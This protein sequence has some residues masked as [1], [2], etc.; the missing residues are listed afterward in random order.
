MPRRGAGKKAFFFIFLIILLLFLMKTTVLKKA[1]MPSLEGVFRDV[2]APV[3]NV[4]VHATRWME[5]VLAAPIALWQ[6]HRQNE[7]LVRE[8]AELRERL[9][10]LEECRL[11]N[12]RLKKL[13]DLQTR[14]PDNLKV[15][16]A[17]VID[18]DPGNWFKTITLNK[19]SRQGVRVNMT[20]VVP[21]GLVGRVI[22]VSDNTAVAM[23]ITDP[24][25]AVSSLVQ[26][27]RSPGIVEG[28]ADPAGRLRMIHIPYDV[29]VR[30]GQAVVTSGLGSLF[31]KG[32]V[33]GQIKEAKKDPSGLFY[34]AIVQPAVDFQ[35]LEEVLIITEVGGG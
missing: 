24:R 20:V 25:S 16:A 27:T 33:I 18:R 26:E 21:E 6:A 31:P 32:I 12:E 23:L 14:T 4:L 13:L 10:A 3:E 15:T 30:E 8:V 2:L 19:G 17:T 35:R 11:E 7:Q 28:T 34:N 1:A 5:N 22:R 29:F 9:Q